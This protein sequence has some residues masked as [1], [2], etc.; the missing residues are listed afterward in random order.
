MRGVDIRVVN[1]DQIL[2][3]SNPL[4]NGV[5]EILAVLNGEECASKRYEKE[6]FN[7]W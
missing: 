5:N 3:Q 1:D 7:P 2:G 6:C 4:D